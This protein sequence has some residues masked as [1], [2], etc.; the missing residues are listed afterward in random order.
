MNKS[1]KGAIAASA[2]AA[3]LLGGAGSLAYWNAEGNIAG[4]TITA[5]E[6][7]LTN[8]AAG[9]WTLN[10]TSVTDVA[11]VKIVPGDTLVYTGE[12]TIKATGQNLKADVDVTGLQASGALA[13]KLTITDSYLVGAT[14]P[15][16]DRITSAD[17]AKK[18]KATVTVALPYGTTADNT[19]QAL[20]M[21]LADVKVTLKQAAS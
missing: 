14:A 6:L 12:W 19:S 21:S 18:L 2:A 20:S 8:P 17:D 15:T 1:T 11:A 16:N 13:S 9:V 10:G 5:G 3:L 7:K 4:G